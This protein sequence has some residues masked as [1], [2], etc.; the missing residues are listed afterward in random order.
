MLSMH[1]KTDTR[2]TFVNAIL[3]QNVKMWSL[4]S[5]YLVS[6]QS[7]CT[8]FKENIDA[9]MYKKRTT[10]SHF[11]HFCLILDNFCAMYIKYKDLAKQKNMVNA[12]CNAC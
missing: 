10:E 2:Y 12:T 5:E 11:G 9:F 1:S 7:L 4:A 8:P 3:S 6:L